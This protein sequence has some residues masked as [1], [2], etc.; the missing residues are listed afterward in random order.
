MSHYKS[1]VRDIEF[2]LFEVLGREEI[3]GTPPYVELDRETVSAILAEAAHL[4]RT[5]L[6]E[7]FAD[8]D[9]NLPVFDPKTHS[10]AVP[11]HL[12][13]SFRALMDSGAWQL[14]LPEELGGHHNP[15]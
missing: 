7:S 2:N 6:A 4:A 11:E 14:E 8:G 13:K 15:P 1:N 5:K 10:V 9:Q 12:K 3:L